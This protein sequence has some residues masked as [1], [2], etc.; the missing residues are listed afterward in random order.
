MRLFLGFIGHNGLTLPPLNPRNT[1]H[2]KTSPKR[3]N[4]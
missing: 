4:T 1:N 2:F 3:N